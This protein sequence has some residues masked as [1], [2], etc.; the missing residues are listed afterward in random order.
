LLLAWTCRER[1]LTYKMLEDDVGP[2]DFNKYVSI[3]KEL[4]P[5][6]FWEDGPPTWEQYHPKG[7][8]PGLQVPPPP[9][10]LISINCEPYSSVAIFCA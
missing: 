2:E 5:E 9:F 6:V 3:D 8:C 1:L 4:L 10:G 7:G